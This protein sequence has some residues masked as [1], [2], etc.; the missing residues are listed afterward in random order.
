LKTS[1]V[2][3]LKAER[4]CEWSADIRLMDKQ[5]LHVYEYTTTTRTTITTVL[6][7]TCKHLNLTTY[8]DRAL[9]ISNEKHYGPTLEL[10]P[11]LPVFNITHRKIG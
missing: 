3:S 11:V 9:Q 4:H 5:T 10:G 2:A 6:L 8:N 1:V 7:E